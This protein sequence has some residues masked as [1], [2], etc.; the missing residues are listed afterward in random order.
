[1]QDNVG[2]GT[3]T[4]THQT[5]HCHADR[6]DAVRATRDA[7]VLVVCICDVKNNLCSPPYSMLHNHRV[8]MKALS[9]AAA[10][11]TFAISIAK[12]TMDPRFR[13]T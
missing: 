11:A 12:N 4:Q 9:L 3:H 5:H 10:F 7:M 13:D 2:S 1:M 8:E 6:D